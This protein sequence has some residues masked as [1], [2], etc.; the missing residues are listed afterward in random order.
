MKNKKPIKK[1]LPSKKKRV[2]K[3]EST[4]KKKINKK[5][6]SDNKRALITI[7]ASL[8]VLLGLYLGYILGDWFINI[9]N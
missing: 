3:K 8:L 5:E 9:A 2:V 4:E 6:L 1:E 7:I